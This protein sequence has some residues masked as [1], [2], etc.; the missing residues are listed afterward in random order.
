MKLIV[1]TL[2]GKQL[3]IEIEDSNSVA[4]IKAV[5]EKD[6]ALKAETLKLIAYGKVLDGDDKK[7]TDYNLKEGDFIVAMQQKAQP[8]KA[9]PVAEPEPKEPVASPSPAPVQPPVASSAPVVVPTAATTTSSSTQPTLPPQVEQAINELMEISQ[10]PREACARALAAAQGVP[11]I[12]FE[13]L[14]SGG[15]PEGDMV[16]GDDPYGDEGDVGMAGAAGGDPFAGFNLDPEVRAQIGALVS[17]ANFGMIRQRLVQDP[18]FSQQFMETLRNNQ[19]RIFE[20][21]T[22]NPQ[23]LMALVLGHNPLQG[24][25][26][27]PGAG[28]A[29]PQQPPPGS[30]Q[31][32]PEDGEAIARLASLGFSKYRA[33]EAYFAMDKNEEQAANFLFEAGA[34]DDDVATQQAIAAS[35]A[36]APAAS[37]DAQPAAEGSAQ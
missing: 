14:M 36:Q 19:P 7:A 12:A 23:L 29:M 18:T 30:I 35:Q 31:V 33:A 20:A 16:E 6:H 4:E 8:K 37:T 1:K 26:G 13:I 10:M 34:E 2:N 17:N 24:V 9:A 32:S 11:D 21:I 22:A 27:G 5:I 15:L 25:G 28:A 3:P